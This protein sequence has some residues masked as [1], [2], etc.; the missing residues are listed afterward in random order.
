MNTTITIN[1]LLPLANKPA[2]NFKVM[3]E[4]IIK[5]SAEGSTLSIFPEDFLYGVLRSYSELHDA[6]QQFESWIKKFCELAKKYRTAIIPGT[7]PSIKNGEIHNSTVYIDKTGT[8]VA[9][10]S[11]NNLWLSERGEYK[12]S[13]QLPKVFDS[14]LGKTA[15]I[16]CWDIFDSRLFKHAIK[17]DAEWIIV[18]AFWSTNQ[19]KDMAMS[20]G[21][22]KNHYSGFSDSKMLDSLIQSRVAEYNIGLIFCNFAGKHDYTGI[23]GPQRAIS[24]NRSQVVTPYLNVQYRASNR[25]EVSLKCRLD[26]ITQS[27]KDFETHYGRRLDIANSYPWTS[28]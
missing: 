18:L 5:N 1:Q 16:I 15:I 2:V 6:G 10:Y 24:A 26:S 21:I 12:P 20:R 14:V 8:V 23:T 28:H 3:Q 25:K 19:S 22:V 7:L 17:Q 11:K 27:I 9:M 4:T 13:L